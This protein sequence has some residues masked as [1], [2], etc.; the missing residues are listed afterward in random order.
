MSR[1]F[2]LRH[3]RAPGD[4]T[5]LTALARDLKLTYPELEIDVDTS[6]PDIWRNNPY[7]T[8]LKNRKDQHGIQYVD[9]QYG[10]GIRAQKTE[11]VHF[12]A[13]F[14]RDFHKRVGI[15]VPLRYPYGDIHLSHDEATVPLVSGRYWVVISGGKSDF[16]AKVWR[17]TKMQETVNRLVEKGLGVVQIGSTDSGH[18]HPPLDNTLNLVGESNLRDMLRLIKHADGVICGVTAAMHMAAALQRPCVMLSGGREAWWWEAYVNEN[19]GFGPLASGQLKVPHRC[20]HT[21]GLLDCCAA[22]GCWKNKV[23]KIS[24]DD[25]L[26]KHP[27]LTPGQAVPLCLEM[28]TPDMV[29]AAAQSY[30]DDGTLP[31]LQP[32]S[33]FHPSLTDAGEVSTFAKKPAPV[34]RRPAL[35]LDL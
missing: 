27:V 24:D 2:V 34:T 33:V 28:I 7:L 22:H 18:W 8:P 19:S 26:C 11:T 20:L 9:C 1:R 12:L 29:V 4:V 14:H 25:S 16:T 30:Y 21:I 3:N 5:V 10:D 35:Q 32:S 15:Q 13:W 6:A 17:I 31:S 23:V